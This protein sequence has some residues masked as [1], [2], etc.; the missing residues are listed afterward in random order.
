MK[1]FEE[2]TFE[3]LDHK[4]ALDAAIREYETAV[5]NMRKKSQ[6]RL[7]YIFLLLAL[8]A[9]LFLISV[10]NIPQFWY[11]PKILM[12]P[13]IWVALI[14]LIIAFIMASG[15]FQQQTRFRMEEKRLRQ[16][17][18]LLTE[19]YAEIVNQLEKLRTAAQ[20]GTKTPPP[21]VH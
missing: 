11:Q 6:I 14:M 13:L 5:R 9:L 15:L 2:L 7:L 17:R 4:E 8:A 1:S 18:E 19:Q 20:R 3:M 12:Q 10:W 21:T 16:K